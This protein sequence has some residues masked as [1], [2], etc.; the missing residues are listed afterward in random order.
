MCQDHANP[1]VLNKR[2]RS[3]VV[4]PAAADGVCTRKVALL[5]GVS[6]EDAG[7]RTICTVG[8]WLRMTHVTLLGVASGPA[9]CGA[10]SPLERALDVDVCLLS[11]CPPLPALLDALVR[12]EHGV[13][14]TVG[15]GVATMWS[16]LR[17]KGQCKGWQ[18]HVPSQ[19]LRFRP[20]TQYASQPW[21]PSLTLPPALHWAPCLYATKCL[22]GVQW[23]RDEGE[24]DGC[25]GAR[26]EQNF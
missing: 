3:V 20:H 12:V 6:E 18:G 11:G 9:D 13:V 23:V 14:A 17:G 24:G 4:R 25:T 22:H 1:T 10:R 21:S 8:G 7:P 16:V 19:Q 2:Y 26:K 5:E 15:G